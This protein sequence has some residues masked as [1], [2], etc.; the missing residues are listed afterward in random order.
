MIPII[1]VQ[2]TLR[3]VEYLT[4][5]DVLAYEDHVKKKL[6][7]QLSEHAVAAG[8]VTF[9]TRQDPYNHQRVLRASMIS[10][11]HKDWEANF[12]NYNTRRGIQDG[13]MAIMQNGNWKVLSN[14]RISVPAPLTKIEK[15]GKISAEDYLKE[16]LRD[17]EIVGKGSR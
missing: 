17:V 16:R 7:V 5:T 10:M 4:A 9:E 13:T 8:C 15:S 11:S 3:E 14:E 2:E 1:A 6:A 12:A